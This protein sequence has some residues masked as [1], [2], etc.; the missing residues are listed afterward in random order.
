MVYFLVSWEC[1]FSDLI[2]IIIII[3]GPLLYFRFVQLSHYVCSTNLLRLYYTPM[4]HNVCL[5]ILVCTTALIGSSR[6]INIISPSLLSNCI[7]PSAPCTTVPLYLAHYPIGHYSL[8]H[9]PKSLESLLVF[10]MML[11]CSIIDNGKVM[12]QCD[13][14]TVMGHWNSDQM[15]QQN[16]MQA[17]V[18]SHGAMGQTY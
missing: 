15:S 13:R 12:G 7:F 9:C 3:T 8:Y 18:M 2:I 14:W 11:L 10:L 6:S 16:C 1:I 5:T 17:N 4:S